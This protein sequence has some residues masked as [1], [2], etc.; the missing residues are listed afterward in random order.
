MARLS[1]QAIQRL[2]V[3]HALAMWRRGAYGP[4]RLHKTL[5]FADRDAKA[6]EPLF[7][8]KKWRLGQYS[9]EISDAL[10]ALQEAGRI[11]SHYDGPSERL[12]AEVSPLARR[13]MEAVFRKAFPRWEKSLHRA[14]EE[15]AYLQNDTIV[16]RA[17][18]DPTYKRSGYGKVIFSSFSAGFVDIPDL[19]PDIAEDLSDLVDVRLWRGLEKRLAEAVK[20]PARREDWRSIYF[21]D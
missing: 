3:L 7:T 21:A 1:K 12:K 6:G 13:R 11:R 5:F 16:E 4:V 20:R 8:F 9:D 19:D 10:N 14:F 2:A 15:W 18:D 17:H